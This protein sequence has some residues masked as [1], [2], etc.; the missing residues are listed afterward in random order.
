MRR[1]GFTLV[2]LLI[3]VAIITIL[4]GLALFNFRE[5][6]RRAVSAQCKSRLR[7]VVTALQMYRIDWNRLPFSDG[8]RGPLEPG[9][10]F[11]PT[12]FGQGPAAGGS[13]NAVP[14]VLVHGP[15]QYMTDENALGCPALQRRHRGE[16]DAWRYAYNVGGADSLGFN[17]GADPF[18]P[19]DGAGVSGARVWLCR[20]LFVN[21]TGVA[22]V[23][24]P[25]F[26][27][28]PDPAPEENVWGEEN[29][30]WNSGEVSQEPG[31][32]PW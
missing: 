27:H 28:G 19:V 23:R 6:S 15:V 5:A 25:G 26:P 8:S 1:R 2:E 31:M 9:Q 4:S 30:L 10:A 3:V 11:R 21:S 24:F 17:G 14:Q 22:P 13:W 20:C 16:E 32:A 7:T 12:A 29:V 18:E